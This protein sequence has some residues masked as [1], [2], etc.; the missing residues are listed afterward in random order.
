VVSLGNVGFIGAQVDPES[1]FAY[2][3]HRYY[4]PATSRFLTPDP[5]GLLGSGVNL[6]GYVGNNPATLAEPSGL[7][8]DNSGDCNDL[9]LFGL[10][11]GNMDE[12]ASKYVPHTNP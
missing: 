7:D 12:H 4:D 11:E 8:R 3:R 5:L 6:Y 9:M 2:L 1:S 10:L